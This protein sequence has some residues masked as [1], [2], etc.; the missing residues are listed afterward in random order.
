MAFAGERNGVWNI[1]DVERASGNVRQLTH[2]TGLE[3]YVRYPAW[4]PTGDRIVFERST[5]TSSIWTAKLW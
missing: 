3:G 5:Q 2:W 1:F 4:A